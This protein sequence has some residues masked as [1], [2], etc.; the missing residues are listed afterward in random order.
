M[1]LFLPLHLVQQSTFRETRFLFTTT[2]THPCCLPVL[3]ADNSI[4][5]CCSPF[6]A[7]YTTKP[8]RTV[9]RLFSPLSAATPQ[10]WQQC[11]VAFLTQTPRRETVFVCLLT[12]VYYLSPSYLTQFNGDASASVAFWMMRLYLTHKS[13]KLYKSP[14]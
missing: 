6:T 14:W 1:C 10:L 7:L 9:Q 2:I 8:P 3:M 11:N 13:L 4:D 5:F 12:T